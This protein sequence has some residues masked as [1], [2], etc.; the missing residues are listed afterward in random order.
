MSIEVKCPIDKKTIMKLKRQEEGGGAT[1]IC[2]ECKRVWL[3][4]VSGGRG[5]AV[6]MLNVERNIRR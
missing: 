4:R 1:F 2:P 5:V 6:E 3:I